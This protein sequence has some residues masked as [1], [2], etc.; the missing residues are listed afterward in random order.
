[1][2]VKKQYCAFMLA[3]QKVAHKIK[4]NLQSEKTCLSLQSLTNTGKFF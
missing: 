2:S 1:M 3:G 4:K